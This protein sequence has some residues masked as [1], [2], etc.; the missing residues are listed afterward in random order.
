MAT[1]GTIVK[2]GASE[3][4]ALWV[5]DFPL[6]GLGR[7]YMCLFYAFGV[8]CIW[9]FLLYAGVANSDLSLTISLAKVGNCEF[10]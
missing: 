1:H 4:V 10:L 3:S 6:N 8:L 5:S 7:L 2:P 9:C